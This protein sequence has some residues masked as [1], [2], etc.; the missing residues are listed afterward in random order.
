MNAVTTNA[1]IRRARRC[2]P[3]ESGGLPCYRGGGQAP[4]LNATA[5]RHRY[6]GRCCRI[7]AGGTPALPGGTTRPP[8]SRYARTAATSPPTT[9]GSLQQSALACSISRACTRTL[10]ARHA[11][12]HP[13]QEWSLCTVTSV[14]TLARVRRAARLYGNGCPRAADAFPTRA[15]RR[16]AQTD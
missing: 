2:A 1:G 13:R 4:L 15:Q 14:A 3:A 8:S 16:T 7:G 12:C 9:A 10:P 6:G 5:G 11:G